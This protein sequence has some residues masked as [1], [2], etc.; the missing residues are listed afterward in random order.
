MIVAEMRAQ[1]MPWR[2][3]GFDNNANTSESSNI[4]APKCLN[5]FFRKS[6]RKSWSD[7]LLQHVIDRIDQWSGRK[8]RNCR[9]P[10]R[11]PKNLLFSRLS[12]KYVFKTLRVTDEREWQ[13]ARRLSNNSRNIW[14][15]A[16]SA[17]LAVTSFWTER[18]SCVLRN[19]YHSCF[20]YQQPDGTTPWV[21]VA[22]CPFSGTNIPGWPGFIV[23]LSAPMPMCSA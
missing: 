17:T 20:P 14:E 11:L 16:H 12:I 5:R 21:A 2:N 9:V 23:M 7:V 15:V 18:G 10:N 8:R 3:S 13:C 22:R 19:G 6:R 4:N 1:T